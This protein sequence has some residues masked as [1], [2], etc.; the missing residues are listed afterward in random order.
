MG[1]QDFPQCILRRLAHCIL[2]CKSTG[3][4]GVLKH[5]SGLFNR[6]AGPV[7]LVCEVHAHAEDHGDAHDPPGDTGNGAGIGFPTG[8]L[9]SIACR[10]IC[11]SFFR[12]C[13]LALYNAELPKSP[14]PAQKGWRIESVTDSTSKLCERSLRYWLDVSPDSPRSVQQTGTLKP[15]R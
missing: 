10:A 6:L 7:L 5:P 1:C 14:H 11:L 9:Q 12:S 2:G 3:S 15:Y 13:V 4:P 8:L